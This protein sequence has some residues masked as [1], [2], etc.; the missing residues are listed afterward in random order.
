MV[1]H[2]VRV[3]KSSTSTII[4]IVFCRLGAVAQLSTIAEKKDQF[5]LFAVHMGTTLLI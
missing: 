1:R 5:K 4:S 2:A 3:G